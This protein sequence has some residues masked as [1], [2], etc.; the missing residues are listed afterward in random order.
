MNFGHV[1]APLG[2][3]EGIAEQFLFPAAQRGGYE[4]DEVAADLAEHRA[5]LWIADDGSPRAAMVTRRDGDTL[6]VWLAGGA[7]LSG[8]VPFLDIALKAATW[9]RRGRLT[10]RKGWARVLAPYG[11]RPSGDDLVKEL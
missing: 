5:Q 9:A 8:C 2:V 3:W 7:V 4:W 6:E 11:W 10:G 1:P